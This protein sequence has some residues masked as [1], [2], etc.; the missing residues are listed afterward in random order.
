MT[1]FTQKL[2]HFTEALSDLLDC[3]EIQ[4]IEI[5]FSFNVQLKL[6]ASK[7]HGSIFRLLRCHFKVPNYFVIYKM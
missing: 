3:S 2:L 5:C 6:E 7:S 1:T 4:N